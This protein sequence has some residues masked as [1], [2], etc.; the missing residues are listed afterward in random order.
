MHLLDTFLR[1]LQ[2]FGD[3]LGCF[4]A[5]RKVCA[6]AL[7]PAL[8]ERLQLCKLAILGIEFTRSVSRE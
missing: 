2:I 4:H 6:I 5:V 1:P 8:S 7:K 3:F